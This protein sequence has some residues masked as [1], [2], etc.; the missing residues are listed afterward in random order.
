MEGTVLD[1]PASAMAYDQPGFAVLA[2]C[3]L[4]QCAEIL[5]SVKMWNGVA[6]EQGLFLPMSTQKRSSG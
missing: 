1:G 3:E 6:H 2:G 4:H 5:D